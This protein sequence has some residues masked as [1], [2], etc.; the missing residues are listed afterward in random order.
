VED[1]IHVSL[2]Q[3]VDEGLF[4]GEAEGIASAVTVVRKRLRVWHV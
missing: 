4:W 3:L 2:V 1:A